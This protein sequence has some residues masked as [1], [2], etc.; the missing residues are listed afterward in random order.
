MRTLARRCHTPLLVGPPTDAL[1][2]A[3]A[4]SGR[5]GRVIRADLLVPGIPGSRPASLVMDDE[6]PPFADGS[7]DLVVSA[8]SLQWVNDL[9]GAL[10]QVRR[11]LRPDG[12]FLATFVGGDSL[13]ELRE[14]F[15]TAEA[16]LTGGATPR[17]A[18]F[19]DVRDLGGLL[20]R[21]GFALPVTDQDRLTLRYAT[22]LDLMRDLKA[23]GAGN[24]LRERSRRPLRRSVLSRAMEIYADRASDPDGR[25]RATIT[26]VSMS[27]WAPHESQQRPL[28][29]GS[30]K[31]R[32]ADVLG[33]REEKLRR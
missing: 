13:T 1:A 33:T 26:L 4:D 7:I 28:R 17:V 2:N 32:L 14:S 19:A 21:A 24:V 9:P 15:L 3:V 20:Q 18:P 12:L 31:V 10:A 6:L 16:E 22:P 11:A 5:V 27:G 23:M 29:P 25:V 30:A 8:L